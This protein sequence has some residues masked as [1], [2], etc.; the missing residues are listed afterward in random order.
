MT[1]NHRASEAQQIALKIIGL[2]VTVRL[3]VML[4][5]WV[6]SLPVPEARTAEVFGQF[7][8]IT[9]FYVALIGL[10]IRRT[11]IAA[12]VFFGRTHPDAPWNPSALSFWI[13]AASIHFLIAALPNAIVGLIYFVMSEAGVVYYMLRDGLT[14][15]IVALAILIAARI[16]YH[17]S[18]TDPQAQV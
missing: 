17:S 15:F 14:S 5:A 2:I 11:A 3:I 16:A 1:T 18:P 10:L 9:L 12:R 7:V 8:L 13:I 6:V 4:S